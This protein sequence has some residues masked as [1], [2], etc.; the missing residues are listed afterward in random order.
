MVFSFESVGLKYLPKA[1]CSYVL[2]SAQ[3][4]LSPVAAACYNTQTVEM[5]NV[6]VAGGDFF[7]T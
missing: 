7:S 4:W 5:N 1:F 6:K 2:S 3:N